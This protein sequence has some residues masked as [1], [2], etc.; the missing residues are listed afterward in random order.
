MNISL[1]GVNHNT[2]PI[3]IRE[4]MA[5]S[6]E[7]LENSLLILRH[8][9]PHGV[10]LSTCNR[11]EVYAVG[12]YPA[13]EAII[14]FLNT[15]TGVSFVDL[16]PH[17]YLRENKTA[18]RHLFRIASGLDSMIIGE[19]EVLGQI[20]QALEAAENANMVTSPLRH[21]FQSAI[22]AGRQVREETG[23]SRSALSVSSVA[24]DL[25]AKIVN[26][27]DSCKMMVIGAGEAGELVA[28]VAKERG[29]SRIVIANRTR[30]RAAA[31]VNTLGGISTD[32]NNL[33]EELSDI[34]IVVTCAG[35]AEH[36]MDIN[37]V[38]DV[39]RD[40][41]DSPLV[42]IDIGV[43][44]NVAPEVK[45]IDNVFLYNI[46]DLTNISELNRQQRTDEV[47]KAEQVVTAEV[48]KCISEWSAFDTRPIIT[49]LMKKAEDIRNQ[50]LNRTIKKLRPLSDEEQ[51]SLEAM[52]KSIITKILQD[53]VQYLKKH[54]NNDNYTGMMSEIFR[55]K[56]EKQE[57]E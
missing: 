31:L 30:E 33:S 5:I 57:E 22:R 21:V 2:A 56:L 28:K 52:T 53:P 35:A 15:M 18:F 24:V 13:E 8:Y 20:R 49:A 37:L 14:N 44:R 42:I 34:D 50:Q 9:V 25:A 7:Q 38:R 23:I 47:Y 39:M 1:V 27:L 41:S 12:S 48:N 45:R 4:K 40:R 26:E 19:Y 10:I 54:N 11:T 51:Y 55:L 6:A 43:P 16:L 29:V 46:D 17:I 32:L 3:T 36:I